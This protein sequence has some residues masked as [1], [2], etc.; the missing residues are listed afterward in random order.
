M[1]QASFHWVRASGHVHCVQ[2]TWVYAREIDVDG[3]NRMV[4]NLAHGLIGRRIERSPLPFGRDRWIRWEPSTPIDVAA[5]IRS[6]SD[7]AVWADQRAA[8]PIDPEAGPSWHVGIVPIENY[9]TAVSIVASHTVIDGLGF[10]IVLADAAKGIT[11]DLGYPPP[12]ARRRLA[13]VADDARGAA[14]GVPDMVRAVAAAPKLAKKA[15]RGK[16]SP[17]PS[18]TRSTQISDADRRIELPTA[19]AYVDIA[20][21][22]ARAKAL[23]GTSNSLF[24]GFAAKLA[25]RTGR[26]RDDGLV[27]LAYPVSDR[28]EGDTRANALKSVELTADPAPVTGEL[29]T[30]R[31]GIK[32]ALTDGLGDFADQEALLPLI[33]FIPLAVARNVPPEAGGFAD[34]PVGCSYLGDLDPAV[35][36][37]DGTAADY[38][39]IRL[40]EQ[41]LTTHSHELSYGELHITSG[42]SCGKVFMAARAYQPWTP[43]SREHL[44][45]LLAAVLADFDLSGTIN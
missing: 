28:T 39:S 35:A 43:N 22:D 4:D 40:V 26:V 33:P 3:L 25:E 15:S 30:L 17:N 2:A 32:Q 19:T 8:V 42:R 24:A 7:V 29:R 23:G 27:T 20:D 14:L 13:A 41:N 21:W 16:A 44:R 36:L 31:A 5:P 10:A 38:F 1:D 34:L 6:Q 37:A 18:R 11:R 9:G 45:G 12:R